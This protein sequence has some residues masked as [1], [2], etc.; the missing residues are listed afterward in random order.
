[1][2][3]GK[4]ARET[5]LH[6]ARIAQQEPGAHTH[7]TETVTMREI[8][9]MFVPKS[10]YGT[11]PVRML[12]PTRMAT[13]LAG[14]GITAGFGLCWMIGDDSFAYFKSLVVGAPDEE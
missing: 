4:R 1:L 11:L 10:M 13:G 2:A 9:E 3:T 7:A 5:D 8:A 12:P 14:W 6:P